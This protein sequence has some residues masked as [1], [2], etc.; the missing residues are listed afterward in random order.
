MRRIIVEGLFMVIAAIITGV[1]TYQA[2]GEH[3]EQQINSQVTQVVNVNTDS[4]VEAVSKL[5]D[6]NKELQQ[7]VTSLESSIENL[8]NSNETLNKEN[9]GLKNENQELREKNESLM[10]KNIAEQMT[11]VD[12]SNSQN[13]QDNVPYNVKLSD[14][15]VIDSKKYNIIER[16]Q[17]SYGYVYDIGYQFL[18]TDNSYAAY[19]LNQDYSYF[20]AA[21]VATPETNP[22]LHIMVSIYVDDKLVKTFNNINKE[23]RYLE[24]GQIEVSGGKKLKIVTE[25]TDYEYYSFYA[26]C[27][28]VDAEL[29]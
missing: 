20:K 28:L 4:A 27:C 5:I 26:F 24:T 16:F 2:G 18:A 15:F 19:N 11:K 8:K 12:E 29:R 21:I 22:D 3:K 10:K 25:V 14:L 6:M 1:F 13:S 17:D 9:E 23:T 7:K